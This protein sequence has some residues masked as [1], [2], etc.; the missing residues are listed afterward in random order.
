MEATPIYNN[1]NKPKNAATNIVAKIGQTERSKTCFDCRG[2]AKY[3][4]GRP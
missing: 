3:L 2:A 4:S 1:V